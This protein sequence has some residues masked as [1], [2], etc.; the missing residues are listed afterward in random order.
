MSNPLRKILVT[1]ALPYGNGAI[2]IGHLVE[3]LQTDIW[4][5][6][7]RLRENDILYVCGD[8]AHGTPIMLK[9]QSLGVEPKDF[10]DRTN[11]EH[12]ADFAK[13]GVSFDNFYTTDS[14]INRQISNDIYQRLKAAGLTDT[15]EIEQLFDPK[16]GIFL[17]DRFIR[18]TCPNCKTPDQYGDVCEACGKTYDPTDLIDP[19]SAI[20]GT[21]PELRRSRHVFLLLEKARQQLLDLFEKGFVDPAIRNKLQEWFTGPLKDWDISRDAPFLGFPIPDEPGKFFHNWFDAPIGYLASLGNK[22]GLDVAGVRDYWNDPDLER[23]HFIG[24]DITY[25]HALFWPAMLMNA[26]L[27]APNKLAIHGFLT[28]NGQKMSKSRGTFINAA[29]YAK[30]CDPQWLRYY[31]ATKLVPQPEDLDLSVEDFINRVNSELV[32]KLANLI[33]RAA[34]MLSRSLEGRTGVPLADAVPLLTEVRAAEA[35]IAQAYEDRNFAAAT[36]QICGLADKVNKYVEDN[37]PWTLVKTHPEEARGVLTAALEAGR[38]LSIYL[39]PVLPDFAR[40]VEHCLALRPQLWR[41]IADSMEAHQIDPFERLV[42]RIDPKQVEAMIEESRESLAPTAPVTPAPAAA[43]AAAPVAAPAAVSATPA[44]APVAAAAP[45]DPNALTPL[46]T[47]DQFMAIDLRVGRV[48]VAEP[49][50]KSDKLMKITL[51]VGPLGL[52]TILAGIKNAYTAERLTGRLVI[53]CANLAPRKMG[54]FGTSEGMILAAGPGGT[55]VF[56]LSPDSGAQPGQ[57]VH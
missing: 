17:P 18:G 19:K 8:D 9:A 35:T 10:T 37:A 12:K 14:E 44:A 39:A 29:V 51:D 4:V 57:R 47:F 13:F 15:R 50:E 32:G 1:S 16:A 36:R 26:G 38:I 31:Y 41:N 30:H 49:L 5:R 53:F 20:T 33:S 56:V 46:C 40:K 6:F 43:P 3:Y 34:P 54:K 23:Y 52:R 48:V 42:D 21:T 11:A 27:A 25:F 22:L 7:Q 2:H 45:V 55:E 24:K 28:V